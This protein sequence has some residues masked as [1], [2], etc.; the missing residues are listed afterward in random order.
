M[1]VVE[2][3][4]G[5]QVA[6][7][8]GGAPD[9]IPV[10]LQHGTG[11]SRL[12]KHPSNELTA[13]IGVRLITADRPGVGGSTPRKGRSLLD[14]VPDVEA[15]ADALQLESFVVAGTPA[16]RRT[17]SPSR[18]CSVTGCRRSDWRLPS[19]PS[20]NPAPRRW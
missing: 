15:V 7:E 11:D 9:G 16:V 1:A 4:G 6:Y 20:T 3:A 19:R 8:V 17:P 10:F 2:V 18:K 5:R 14:W 13:S 12:C